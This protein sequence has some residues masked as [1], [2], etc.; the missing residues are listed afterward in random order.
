MIFVQFSPLVSKDM[1]ELYFSNR[2]RSLG[3]DVL[4]VILDNTQT[5]AI[6]VFKDHLS[7]LIFILK[8]F[9]RFC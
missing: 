6:I 7:M 3:G 1:L 8:D 4:K 5:C 9:F 2:K